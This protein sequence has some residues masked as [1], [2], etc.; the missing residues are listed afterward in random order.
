[1]NRTVYYGQYK[2]FGAGANETGRAP[3]S[4]ELNDTEAAPFVSIDYIDGGLWVSNLTRWIG[5]PFRLV[6]QYQWNSTIVLYR[7]FIDPRL[8]IRLSTTFRAHKRPDLH[9]SNAIQKLRSNSRA[10]RLHKSYLATS[11]CFITHQSNKAHIS[12]YAPKV[13]PRT[14]SSRSSTLL[15]LTI[16][17]SSN[18][19]VTHQELCEQDIK[20]VGKTRIPQEYTNTWIH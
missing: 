20:W 1:M 13:N 15:H 8:S 3:W 16:S 18:Q 2:C 10:I 17:I 14:Y 11:S 12:H 5:L 19:E 4:H 6:Y 9:R 7:F